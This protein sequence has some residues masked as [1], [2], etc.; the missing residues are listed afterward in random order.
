MKHVNNAF[1]RNI[2]IYFAFGGVTFTVLKFCLFSNRYLHNTHYHITQI[3]F[4]FKER[5][6]V[7]SL[8][9]LIWYTSWDIISIHDR[10]IPHLFVYL[11]FSFANVFVYMNF[12][13]YFL[14]YSIVYMV[15]LKI[16]TPCWLLYCGQFNYFVWFFYVH[17]L[18]TI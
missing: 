13:F 10:H 6:S 1:Y 15:F 17:K 5:S 14:T 11:S 18:L 16:I 12:C 8:Y 4:K 2:Q 9:N 3:K 7:M